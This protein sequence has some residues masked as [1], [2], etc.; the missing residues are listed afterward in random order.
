M[1][2]VYRPYLGVADDEVS[3]S[4]G[5]GGLRWRF[6]RERENEAE[7][8]QNRY[9]TRC[10]FHVSLGLDS[11]ERIVVNN[12]EQ[13]RKQQCYSECPGFTLTLGTMGAVCLYVQA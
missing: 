4:L 12:R 9:T 5:F 10:T 3:A 8:Q 11:G 2:L 7:E 13:L 1:A 6:N